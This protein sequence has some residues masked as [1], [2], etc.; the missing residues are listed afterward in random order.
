M[1]DVKITEVDAELLDFFR[2]KGS[3]SIADAKAALPK[4][5]AIDA[6]IKMLSDP[7][8]GM[9]QEEFDTEFN[10]MQRP[11]HMSLGTYH[12]T[13]KGEIALEDHQAEKRRTARHDRLSTLW[14]PIAVG[15]L[16]YLFAYALDHIFG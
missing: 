5:G 9:L 11:L 15:L 7:E 13:P 6:R 14:A 4:I 8:L 12:I 1:D 16:A 10:P 3:A 2:R